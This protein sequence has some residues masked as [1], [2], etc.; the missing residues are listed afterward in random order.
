MSKWQEGLNDPLV[1]IVMTVGTIMILV[2]VG[3]FV[4]LFFALNTP[5][6]I[7]GTGGC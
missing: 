4:Y 5:G 3:F 1:K 6:C 7:Y 2:M